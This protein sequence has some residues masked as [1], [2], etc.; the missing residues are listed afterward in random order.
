[1]DVR[2]KHEISWFHSLFLLP[3]FGA[4]K[5]R[6]SVIILIMQEKVAVMR[7]YCFTNIL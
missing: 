7:G 1:M 2:I 3:D 5:Y 6:G 4:V